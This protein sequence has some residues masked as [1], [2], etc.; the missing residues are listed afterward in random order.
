MGA[1]SLHDLYPAKVNEKLVSD[2]KLKIWDEKQKLAVAEQ[3][4]RIN[5]FDTANSTSKH[6]KSVRTHPTLNNHHFFDSDQNLSLRDKLRK[7][8]LDNGLECLQSFEKQYSDIKN[9]YDCILYQTKNGWRCVIDIAQGNLEK[10]I[11]LGEYSKTHDIKSIDDFL[12]ISINVHDEGNVLEIVGMCCKCDTGGP[13]QSPDPFNDFS[14][15]TASHGTHVASI[16]S[17]NQSSYNKCEMD[18]V[19]PAAKIVSLTIGD[20]RLGS[21][22]TGTAIIRAMLKIMEL[23]EAGKRVHLINMSYGEFTHWSNSGFVKFIFCQV[24]IWHKNSPFILHL[25]ISDV[26]AKL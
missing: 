13:Q 3:S 4:R 14:Y 16:A 12:S 5:E 2:S 18:G 21:M 26:S 9:T 10:A 22:E 6:I 25:I 19:A 11:V 20:G 8:D 24:K 1:K 23:C 17:G 7:D 15:L